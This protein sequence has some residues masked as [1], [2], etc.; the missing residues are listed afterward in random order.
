MYYILKAGPKNFVKV[1]D[2]K[3]LVITPDQSKATQY[4]SAGDAMRAAVEVNSA[5]G[6]HS[7]KF[8]CV[9]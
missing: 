2:H 9:E 5:L 8:I 1:K 7:V 4:E 6:T 3:E